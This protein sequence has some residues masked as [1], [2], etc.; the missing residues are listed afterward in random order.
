M[1]KSSHTSQ[2]RHA[3]QTWLR[4]HLLDAPKAPHQSGS[5]YS[6]HSEPREVS[7]FH[8]EGLRVLCEERLFGSCC[9]IAL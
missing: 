2:N 9:I 4:G 1:L 8:P 3:W 7:K 5:D 6:I